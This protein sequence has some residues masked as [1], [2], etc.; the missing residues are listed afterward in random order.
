M[1]PLGIEEGIKLFLA[2][3]KPK[4]VFKK[5][6]INAEDGEARFTTIIPMVY[7]KNGLV[8][9]EKGEL[10]PLARVV[11]LNPSTTKW[12]DEVMIK[13]K[14]EF[15]KDFKCLVSMEAIKS[16][17]IPGCSMDKEQWDDNTT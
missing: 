6:S 11:I 3:S 13:I 12:M 15:P 14:D 1:S 9:M 17:S 8:S 10:I 4:G 7:K 16:M 5:I 2:C